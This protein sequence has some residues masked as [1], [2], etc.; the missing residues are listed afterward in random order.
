MF[1]SLTKQGDDYSYFI[2]T[3]DFNMPIDDDTISSLGM[4]KNFDVI[5]HYDFAYGLLFYYMSIINDDT[6]KNKPAD[7]LEYILVVY[8]K[9]NHPKYSA[10]EWKEYRNNAWDNISY[11]VVIGKNNDELY[12]FKNDIDTLPTLNRVNAIHAVWNSHKNDIDLTDIYYYPEVYKFHDHKNTFSIE[13]DRNYP[14]G[15]SPYIRLTDDKKNVLEF[16]QEIIERMI[17][18]YR[19]GSD[20]GYHVTW[21]E[22]LKDFSK[23]YITRLLDVQD[24]CYFPS[25]LIDEDQYKDDEEKVKNIAEY[26]AND[27]PRYD[28]EF[29]VKK[30]LVTFRFLDLR[31]CKFYLDFSTE[32]ELNKGWFTNT[33]KFG[34]SYINDRKK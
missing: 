6:C 9:N 18:F 27:K 16:V 21:D 24:D 33:A 10:S 30:H 15:S 7:L 1:I 26:K 19:D 5:N 17:W 4:N 14:P 3:L 12:I 25:E 29:N 11:K 34:K 20:H 8:G 23:D 13:L 28:V 32:A 31:R 22:R 2:D